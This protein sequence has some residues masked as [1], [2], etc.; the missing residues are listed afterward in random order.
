MNNLKMFNQ[1]LMDPKTQNYLHEVLGERK[2]SFVNNVTSLVNSNVDLQECE[3]L[4]VLYSAMKATALNLPLDQNL[5]F[6]YVLPYNCKEKV[7]ETVTDN[8]G[9]PKVIEKEVWKKLAQ[10]QL[11]YKGFVQLAMRSGQFKT[12]NVTDI[13]EGEIVRNDLLSGEIEISM[14]KSN[15]EKAKVIGYAAYFKLINGFEKTLYM[16]NEKLEQHG[17]RFSKSYQKNY[18]L[19]K[20][21]FESMAKKTVLKL[22]ISKYAPLSIEMQNAIVYDQSVIDEN[23][24]TYIDNEAQVIEITE[25]SIEEKKAEL[26]S[27]QAETTE[28]NEMP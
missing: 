11:G 17:K 1:K 27:K 4:T 24:H 23:K 8:K 15:R 19:W 25:K 14:L 21:D 18:G 2:G 6:A 3:P 5:G 20:D 7:K 9:V 26:K 28:N 16:C 12:I 22:L 13:R 10:F